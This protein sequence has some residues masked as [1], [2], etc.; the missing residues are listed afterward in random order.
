MFVAWQHPAVGLVVSVCV[1]FVFNPST[2]VCVFD[3]SAVWCVDPGNVLH[4]VRQTVVGQKHPLTGLFGTPTDRTVWNTH[5]PDCFRSTLNYATAA[6]ED[7]A[8]RTV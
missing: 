4:A 1:M 8:S 2:Y 7:V 5:R 3:D 6:T